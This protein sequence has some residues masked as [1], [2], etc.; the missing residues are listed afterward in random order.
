MP[1]RPA[2]TIVAIVR[3][4]HGFWGS[5][6]DVGHRFKSP[7]PEEAATLERNYICLSK[8][9]VPTHHWDSDILT[10]TTQRRRK[11]YL[12]K[13]TGV[14][15]EANRARD[16]TRSHRPDKLEEMYAK[17]NAW[18]DKFQ[19]NFFDMGGKL[20]DGIMVTAEGVSDGPFVEAKSV[21]GGSA[22]IRGA[23]PPCPY[24]RL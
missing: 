22:L 2:S 10:D 20:G 17:F 9:H 19:N 11:R 4:E 18:R 5:G 15:N 12:R 13:T 3:I 6:P 1:G 7:V 14:F 8:T 24:E 23:G 16:K 21:I